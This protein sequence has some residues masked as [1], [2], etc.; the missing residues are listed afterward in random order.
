M[1][2]KGKRDGNLRRIERTIIRAM[3][4]VTLIDRKNTEKLMGMLGIEQSLD[5]MGKA[6]S[7]R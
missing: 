1:V 4:G 2:L 3:H 7:M 5:N 6:S